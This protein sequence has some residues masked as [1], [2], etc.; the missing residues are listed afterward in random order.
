MSNVAKARRKAPPPELTTV[1]DFVRY[2][3]TRFGEAKLAFG[4][5]THDAVEE[6]IFLVFETLGLP[7]DR[8]DPFLPARLTAAERAKLFALIEK[9]ITS[10]VPAA[11]LLHC[12]Y[13]QGERF[14][15]DER[16]IVPRS[17][18]AELIYGEPFSGE[19]PLVDASAVQSVLE[20]CTGS[21]CLAVLACRAFP[22]AQVDAVE[23]SK[24]A[25]AVAKINVAEH[26]LEERIRLLKG[27]L[28]APVGEA[29]YDLIIA[30]PPYVDAEAVAAFPAEYKREPLLAH[31]GG[32]DG[33]DIVRR[34]L[35]RAGTHLSPDGGLLCEIGRGRAI[36]ERDYPDLGFLWLDTA[37]SSG[38]VF[39]LPAEEL[40]K[41][42]D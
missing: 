34:I 13:L 38:E 25:L 17:Y 35:E 8:L 33:L 2:A 4:Q 20:L 36:L 37:Q 18:L 1:L 23:L 15:V 7:I 40:Q 21:G 28:F 16:V 41:T 12:A 42:T 5:N 26:G 32:A 3:V 29:V 31:K 39:W 27:D 22:N 6:A 9:R 10:R 30:N 11:Y 24:D 14:Y 19:D